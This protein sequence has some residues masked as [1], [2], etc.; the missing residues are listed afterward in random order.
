MR[1]LLLIGCVLGLLTGALSVAGC[2]TDQ[3][4]TKAL[5]LSGST[6]QQIR[7]LQQAVTALESKNAALTARVALFEAKAPIPGP[8]GPQGV[9]GVQGEQGVQGIQGPAGP[10]GPAAETTTTVKP[11]TTTVST[12]TTTLLPTTTTVKPTTTTTIAPTTTTL[13]P[14]T[15]TTSG[16]F[17]LQA[18]IDA[19]PSGGTVNIPAGTFFFDPSVNLKSGVS[20]KG[21]G[22]DQTILN[23][24][25]ETGPYAFLKGAGISNVTISDM[26]L[27]S[28]G[29][30]DNVFAIWIW[31]YTN[32]TVERVKITNCMYWL[33]ADTGGTGLTLADI[34]VRNCGQGYISNLTGGTFTSLDLEVITQ[35]LTGDT[36]HAIY[37]EG[38]NHNLI[39][40]NT[41]A[42]GGSGW[43]IQLYEETAPSDNITFNGLNVIGLY[44]VMVDTRF[45]NITIRNMTATATNAEAVVKVYGTNVLVDGFTASGGS[46]LV[47][48]GSPS[49]TFRNGTYQGPKLGTGAIFENVTLVP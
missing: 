47:L 1:R 35:K 25:A 36:F 38:N 42:V 10:P 26:T 46:Q 37:L 9:Q 21:A 49:V 33:K 16:P 8:M 4:A 18:A 3:S 24:G 5:T 11:T 41:R 19:C 2:D 14:T 6:A 45:S 29:P 28:P 17:N 48:S 12:T 32:V 27:T 7:Q 39:F 43:T 40:T 20:L 34:T 31:N 22:I 23:H 13:P 44:P 30:A 15:T